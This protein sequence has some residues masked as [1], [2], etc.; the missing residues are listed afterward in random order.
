MKTEQIQ[1]ISLSRLGVKELE[2]LV[3]LREK[4]DLLAEQKEKLDGMINKLLKGKK[5]NYKP[6]KEDIVVAEH[7]GRNGKVKNKVIALLQQSGPTGMHYADIA[8]KVRRSKS[9]INVW[10][11]LVGKHLPIERVE[12]GVYR[13][14]EQKTQAIAA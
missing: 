9:A 12:R 11:N 14:K 1:S 4:S 10:F 2:Q 8:K 13:W 5:I 3:E 6:S 7:V